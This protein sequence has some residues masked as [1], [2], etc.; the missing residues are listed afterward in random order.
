[1]L[2]HKHEFTD[3]Y[4]NALLYLACI[5]VNDLT[6]QDQVSRAYNLAIAALLSKDIYNFGELLLHPILDSLKD[7]EHAWLRELLFAF[8]TGDLRKYRGLTG[9]LS[10]EPQLSQ[11][12]VF[13]KEKIYLSSLTEAIARRPPHER[14]LSFQTIQH[15]TTVSPDEV[16]LLLMRALSLKLIKGTIDQ[17]AE[18]VR[19]T[20]VQ[21]KV[22]DKDQIENM[23]LRLNE[24]NEGVE[25]LTSRVHSRMEVESVF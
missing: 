17:V 18:V 8:N 9:Y 16:E 12:E 21:P 7:T 13:L 14:T 3:Y 11:Q 20:W 6:I 4:R 25:K 5:S 22:L 2:Q 15:E 24:W 1:V 19:V 10:K 23:R